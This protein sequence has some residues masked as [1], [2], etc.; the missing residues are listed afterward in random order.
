MPETFAVFSSSPSVGPVVWRDRLG[1]GILGASTWSSS[2]GGMGASQFIDESEARVGGCHDCGAEAPAADTNYTVV[3][4]RYGWRLTRVTA[5]AQADDGSEPT[6]SVEWRCPSCWQ[7][8]N[9]RAV[10]SAARR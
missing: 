5:D 6:S 9:G 1:L 8:Y 4:S 2:E 10:A 3:T 7:R